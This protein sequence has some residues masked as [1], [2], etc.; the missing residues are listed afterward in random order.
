MGTISSG[1]GLISG[2]DIEGLV[3]SLLQIDARPRDTLL[4]RI[5]GL[6]TRQT[7]FLGLQAQL[8]AVRLGAVNFGDD[9]VFEQKTAG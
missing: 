6:T 2:L 4:R 1:V 3:G 8:L 7:A 9:A 5:E